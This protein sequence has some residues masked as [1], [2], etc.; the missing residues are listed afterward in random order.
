MGKGKDQ[1]HCLRIHTYKNEPAP[2]Y[3]ADIQSKQ[4]N[5]VQTNLTC[6]KGAPSPPNPVHI[7]YISTQQ[8]VNITSA[9]PKFYVSNVFNIHMIS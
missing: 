9:A 5:A 3:I 6:K 7:Q 8:H 2:F 1:Q 4:Q